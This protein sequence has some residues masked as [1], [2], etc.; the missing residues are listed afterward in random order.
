MNSLK[1]N[2][3]V[4]MVLAVM[5]IS[6]GCG[7]RTTE[8]MQGIFTK[9]GLLI[10][11]A[12]HNP[13]EVSIKV[14][15]QCKAAGWRQGEN[16]NIFIKEAWQPGA[17]YEV[18]VDERVWSG[19]A[20]VNPTPWPVSAGE[21]GALEETPSV[22]DWS[23][24]VYEDAAVS[25][26]GKYIGVASFDHNVYLF[27][28]TGKKLWAYLIPD[29]VGMAVAFAA[30]GSILFVGESSPDANIYAFDILTGKVLWRYG[31]AADVGQSDTQKWK[32]RPKITNL[33][34]VGDKVITSA[35]YT[36]RIATQVEGK[37]KVSYVTSCVVRAFDSRTGEQKWRYPET[38]TMDT[39]VSRITCAADGSKVIF[40]NHSWSRGKEY[41]DGSIRILAGA[42][43]KLIGFQQLEPKGGNFS[44]VGIFDGIHLSPN[45]KYLAV[46]T[47][48]NRGMLFDVGNIINEASRTGAIQQ[49]NLL[50][51]I[52]NSNIQQVGGVPVYVYGN[53]AQVNDEGIVHFMT[54]VTF[55][56][57][58]TATSGAPPFMHPDA[59]TLFAYSNRGELLWKWQ[60]EGGVGNLKFS[61][62]GRY[63]II[64]ISH[65]YVTQQK[66][67]SG[68]YC[69]DLTRTGG[70]P[71]VWFYPLEGVAVAG[72]LAGNDT[73]VAGVEVPIRQTDDRPVG[74]HRLHILQ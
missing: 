66:D 2:I 48:D 61:P 64:P 71:L 41:I 28:N 26:D 72:G 1:K 54:G 24:V 70:D 43:G 73:T 68:V 9:N 34:V 31:M 35:E 14:D 6:A 52:Q 49:F 56:A 55:V 16:G 7:G 15:G 32:N 37:G 33:A 25:P 21:L 29:G 59:T 40:A 5:L 67:K 23:P 62:N 12:A 60:T 20:P 36:Q 39:G 19:T 53:T 69:L 65:N 74:K 17:N 10:I 11:N 46:I 3:A 30:D 13:K 22:K 45:G 18:S 27:D 63:V 58:K 44:Y 8:G 50:W 38:G 47:A 57:D 51:L 42:T 4:C